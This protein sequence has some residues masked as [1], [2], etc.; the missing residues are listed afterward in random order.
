MEGPFLL[1]DPALFKVLKGIS[2][3][4]PIT[5]IFSQRVYVGSSRDVGDRLKAHRQS[6]HGGTHYNE[7]LQRIWNRVRDDGFEARLLQ[8]VG[9]RKRLQRAEHHWIAMLGALR[10]GFNEVGIS[11]TKQGWRPPKNFP[12]N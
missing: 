5:H 6:L 7:D 11:P 2:G 9:G 10:T 12:T 4:Y 1:G 3:V 8:R